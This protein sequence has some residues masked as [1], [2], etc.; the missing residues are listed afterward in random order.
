MLVLNSSQIVKESQTLTHRSYLR[1][2]CLNLHS[3]LFILLLSFKEFIC[4]PLPQYK[5]CFQTKKL[6]SCASFLL[7]WSDLVSPG[8]VW[9]HIVWS[10]QI[11]SGVTDHILGD[12][13]CSLFWL[14][15]PYK[16]GLRIL[17]NLCL[18]L[19]GHLISEFLQKKYAPSYIQ[20]SL[21]SLLII[22]SSIKNF[23]K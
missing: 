13:T 8:L 6:P 22:V 10:G 19:R 18:E 2:P 14:L 17:I 16:R 11:L 21:F 4:Q 9:C 5:N 12:L 23:N 1:M 3:S 20:I 7:I 15:L